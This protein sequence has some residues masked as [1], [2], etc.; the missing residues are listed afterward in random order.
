MASMYRVSANHN[1]KSQRVDENTLVWVRNETVV[2]NTSRK[3]N[4]KWRGPY[5]VI[6]A[7]RDGATY[8]LRNT[9]DQTVITRAAEKV[10][11]FVGQE[12]WLLEMQ[13]VE[14]DTADIVDA[15]MLTKGARNRVP[16][17]RFIEE[18]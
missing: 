1:R 2:P 14:N 11:H 10:K 15:G 9:F 6:R 8:E 7:N 12:L 17:Q 5:Q 3:L 18:F 4:P 13:E 16:P